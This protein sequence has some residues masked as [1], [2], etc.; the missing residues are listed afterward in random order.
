MHK[1]CIF[2][3]HFIFFVVNE[4]PKPKVSSY[5]N[6]KHTSNIVRK[7]LLDDMTFDWPWLFILKGE[8]Y[9]RKRYTNIFIHKINDGISIS[10]R[11][12]SFF[13]FRFFPLR[14]CLLFASLLYYSSS[15]FFFVSKWT[16]D[17]SS[18]QNCYFN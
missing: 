17:I 4:C 7:C 1:C 10:F 6:A 16:L 3:L 11:G 14:C 2:S 13:F 9:E 18:I 8:Q 15:H 12:L 5:Y